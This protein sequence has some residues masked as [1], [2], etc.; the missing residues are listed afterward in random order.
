MVLINL[1]WSNLKNKDSD[2]IE[3]EV[4]IFNIALEF[5]IINVLASNHIKE[6]K[7]KILYFRGINNLKLNIY[8]FRKNLIM[9]CI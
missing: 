5:I 7:N 1:F 3:I 6:N 2:L 9:L 8:V 4:N